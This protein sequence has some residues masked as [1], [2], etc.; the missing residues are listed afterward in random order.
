MTRGRWHSELATEVGIGSTTNLVRN[1]A[2]AQRRRLGAS[3]TPRRLDEQHENDV[4]GGAG[5]CHI[6]K[7]LHLR[8]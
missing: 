7:R 3:S 4:R 1:G 2:C 5:A 6:Q 8:G